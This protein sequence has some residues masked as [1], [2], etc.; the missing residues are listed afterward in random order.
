MM[1]RVTEAKEGGGSQPD[2]AARRNGSHAQPSQHGQATGKNNANG[3]SAP[4]AF[5]FST[6]RPQVNKAWKLDSCHGACFL[7]SCL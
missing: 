6:V 2:R 3:A 1:S 5:L 4:I 7:Y